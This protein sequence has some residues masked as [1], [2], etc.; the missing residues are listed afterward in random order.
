M[1]SDLNLI[2][3]PLSSSSL[4]VGKS[5]TI[6]RRAAPAGKAIK[7]GVPESAYELMADRATIKSKSI[8]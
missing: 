7:T 4:W 6:G 5:L 1:T 8:Y 3:Q 2:Q